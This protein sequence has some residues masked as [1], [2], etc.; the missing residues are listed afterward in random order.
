MAH[1]K[2]VLTRKVP[3]DNRSIMVGGTCLGYLIAD[4]SPYSSPTILDDLAIAKLFR[5]LSKWHFQT[6]PLPAWNAGTNLPSPPAS[7]SFLLP[8]VILTNPGGVPSV[9]ELAGASSAATEI[10]TGHPVRCIQ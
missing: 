3:S 1:K 7:K 8:R 6:K 10:P 4:V 9:V 5:R 2:V